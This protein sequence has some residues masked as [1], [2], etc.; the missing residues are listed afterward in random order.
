MEDNRNSP[1]FFTLNKDIM[2][3]NENLRVPQSN[4]NKSLTHQSVRD[5]MNAYSTQSKI[6]LYDDSSAMSNNDV[7]GVGG[8]DIPLSAL[9]PKQTTFTDESGNV[10]PIPKSRLAEESQSRKDIASAYRRMKGIEESDEDADYVEDDYENAPRAKDLSSIK[11]FSAD[12]V[13]D[14]P[15]DDEGLLEILELAIRNAKANLEMLESLYAA[16]SG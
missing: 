5:I 10:I 9:R 16:L 13:E 8:R 1:P 11:R 15:D 3:S 12:Y 14:M 6:Q 7:S 2:D 4:V